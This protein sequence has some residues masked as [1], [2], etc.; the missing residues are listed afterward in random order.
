MTECENIRVVRKLSNN[1][2]HLVSSPNKE[3]KVT[4]IKGSTPSASSNDSHKNLGLCIFIT[5]EKKTCSVLRESELSFIDFDNWVRGR[6]GIDASTR[7]GYF[8][9]DEA[10]IESKIL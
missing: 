8:N 4:V 6:F 3:N 10:G 1:I 9:K 2:T 5:F 7:L